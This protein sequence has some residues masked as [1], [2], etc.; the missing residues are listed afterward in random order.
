MCAAV[1]ND[2]STGPAQLKAM[3][4]LCHLYGIAVIF[5]VVYNHA[6]GF[7]GDD[8]SIFFG[9][10]ADDPYNMNQSL[11]F[12]DQSTAGG[13]SFA[14]WNDAVRQFLINNAN[15][16]I[17]EFHVDGFRYDE[18]SALL[19]MNQDSGWTFCC[20]LTNTIRYD[21]AASLLNAEYWEGDNQNY[22]RSTARF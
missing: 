21:Q 15:Y 6:G 20:D 10:R 1:A 4:D 14:L 18:I 17:D 19:S 8:Q 16:Y 9:D 12:T 5:D 7:E 3:V 13:L 22:F 11:Y 2:I